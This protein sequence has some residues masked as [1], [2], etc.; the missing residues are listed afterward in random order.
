MRRNRPALR[1]LLLT[2]FLIPAAQ[3]GCERADSVPDSIPSADTSDATSTG[4]SYRLLGTEP[5]WALDIAGEELRF[6]TPEDTAGMMLRASETEAA[7]DTLRWSGVT[8]DTGSFEVALWDD[9]CSDGMSD[10]TWSHRAVVRIGGTEYRG[11]G[12]RVAEPD[13][14]GG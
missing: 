12:E 13:A 9:R 11:C 4:A 10:K 6:K 5:F 1:V 14:P 7:G 3:T 2:A 8:A